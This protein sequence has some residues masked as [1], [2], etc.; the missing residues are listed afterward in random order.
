LRN[1]QEAA[2]V[3]NERR[4]TYRVSV[5]PSSGIT[6]SMS[7]V[8]RSWKATPGNISAEGMFVRLQPDAPVSLAVNT[9]VVVDITYA[10]ETLRLHGAIRSQRA[11][12]YGIFFPTRTEDGY[13]NPV[14]RLGQICAALQVDELS[15]RLFVGKDFFTSRDLE[16]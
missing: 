16:D 1:L 5:K 11:G 13:I 4:A 8:D 9:P 15:K 12:G 10:E 14:S 7:L 3:S 2:I 6:A